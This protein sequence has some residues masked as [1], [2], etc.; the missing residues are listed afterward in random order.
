MGLEDKRQR[1][2]RRD[3]KERR[4]RKREKANRKKRERDS[5]YLL[6]ITEL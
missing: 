5:V 3:E 2:T 6:F 1:K 4:G